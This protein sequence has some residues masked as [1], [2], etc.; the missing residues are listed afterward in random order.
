LLEA[1]RCVA[2][3]EA[4]EW[5]F[6]VEIDCLHAAG[7]TNTHLRWLLHRGYALQGVERTAPG[8]RR[9]RFRRVGN[10]SLPTAT[11]FVLTDAGAAYALGSVLPCGVEV[12][13]E[14]HRHTPVWD[15]AV[16]ELRVGGLIVKRFKQPAANQELV[17]EAFQEE[18]WPPR[19]DDPLPPEAEQDPKRRLHSTISNLNRGQREIKVHFTGGGEGQSVCWRLLGGKTAGEGRAKAERV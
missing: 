9:R 2:E 15:V 13:C 8:A 16:R 10:L 5:D 4:D 1:Y 7:L 3:L 17:L 19:I 18:G 14:E 11:C 12:T 6:A